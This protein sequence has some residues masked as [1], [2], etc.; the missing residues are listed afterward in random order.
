M[1]HGH[2]DLEWKKSNILSE[3]MKVTVS[4]ELFFIFMY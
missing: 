2:L 1:F 4:G 3:K